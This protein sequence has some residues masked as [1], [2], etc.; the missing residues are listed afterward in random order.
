MG[1]KIG[2]FIFRK[3]C[4]TGGFCILQ[5]HFDA[6]GLLALIEQYRI[7]HVHL[8][9]TMFVRLL[10][11]IS[12]GDLP[13]LASAFFGGAPPKSAMSEPQTRL[14]NRLARLLRRGL[15][16]FRLARGDLAEHF[17]ETQPA[18]D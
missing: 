3:C 12:G 6:E 8:F 1:R 4:R 11:V 17:L 13:P 2:S 16:E 5:P 10:M 14:A 9:P 7:T 18:F 15:S